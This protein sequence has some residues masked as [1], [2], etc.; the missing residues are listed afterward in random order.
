M[1]SKS[2][3]G[4]KILNLYSI[5]I[6][7]IWLIAISSQDSYENLIERIYMGITMAIGSFIAGATSEGGGA[8][9][10]PVMTMVYNIGPDVSRDYSLLIQSCGMVAAS[11]TIFKNKIPVNFNVILYTSLGA[12]VGN[13]IG[14][15]Y[16]VNNVSTMLIKLSFCS[17]W[18]SFAIIFY[19]THFNAKDIFQFTIKKR[20]KLLLLLLG[21]IGGIITTLFGTGADIVSFAFAT[22]YLG[23]SIQIATPT[24]VVIM[25]INS[26]AC[27]F[28]KY[29]YFGGIHP[30]AFEFLLVSMP[31]VIIG[32]PLGALY[33]SKKGKKTLMI[34]L[35][36]AISLQYFFVLTILPLTVKEYIYSIGFV[37]FGSLFWMG[38]SQLSKKRKLSL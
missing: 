28:I 11:F 24:S 3:M 32:A 6:F 34:L 19:K 30:E 13:F 27:L 12:I 17:I 36:T 4:K 18:M 20:D 29:F 16:I 22:L 33:I 37:V 26:L 21:V 9:A 7:I 38:I 14:F 8:V 2:L 5:S 15:N 10:F 1:L 23:T 31:V 35:I 25:A